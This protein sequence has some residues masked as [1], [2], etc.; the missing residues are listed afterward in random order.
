[1]SA[2]DILADIKSDLG[3][4]DS[5]SDEWLGRRIAGIWSRMEHYTSRALCSPP[6]T[7]IDDWGLISFNG[8]QLPSPPATWVPP[9]A[10]VFLRYFP[11]V[12][13]EAIEHDGAA[14][15]PTKVRWDGRTG[16]LFNFDQVW[17]E[18]LGPFLFNS[19]TRVTYKAGWAE[20]PGD[21]YEIVLGSMQALWSGRG[22][23]SGSGGV[24]GTI[25]TINVVDVGSVEL[26]QGN[27]FVE[28]TLKG[29]RVSDPLLGPYTSLLDLYVD[30]RNLLGWQGQPSTTAV[31]P[32]AAAAAA[33]PPEPAP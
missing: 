25:N 9:R 2:P 7:F 4:T 23:S 11:V 33:A 3:I 28:S 1:M 31:A 10:S 32:A 8:T 26:G 14:G 19:R 30:E 17:A 29:V 27:A 18:D 16:K 24:Q 6:Q 12:S 5:A 20:L 21:L 15:D 22:G 13:I